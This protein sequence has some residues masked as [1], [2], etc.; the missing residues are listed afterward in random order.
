M[1]G[2]SILYY[3]IIGDALMLSKQSLRLLDNFNES[4][5]PP[6]APPLPFDPT[7]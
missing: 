5:S 6:S 7:D 1:P 2:L 4:L 3:A